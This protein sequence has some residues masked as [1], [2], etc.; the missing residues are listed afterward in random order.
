MDL[1]SLSKSEGAPPRNA[2]VSPPC[3]MYCPFCSCACPRSRLATPPRSREKESHRKMVALLAEVRAQ[4]L[5]DNPY[6]GEGRLRQLE[7]QL[8][9]LPDAAPATRPNSASILA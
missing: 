5:D 1:E 6:Q 9:A 8:Q 7:D 4:D 3:L 2:G